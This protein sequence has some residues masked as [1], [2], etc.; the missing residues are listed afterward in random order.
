MGFR[1]NNFHLVYYDFIEFWKMP[2]Y[3]FDDQMKGANNIACNVNN[4]RIKYVMWF[5]HFDYIH[6]HDKNKMSS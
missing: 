3:S 4:F 6:F 5:F 2:F 1:V